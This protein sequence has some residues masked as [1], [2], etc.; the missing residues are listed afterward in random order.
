MDKWKAVKF[1]VISTLAF[2]L[3]NTFAKQLQGFHA[4]EIIFFRSLGSFI[5]CMFILIKNRIPIL[6]TQ[7]PWLIAR[8]IAGAIAMAT[9]FMALQKL[10]FGSVVALRYLSPVFAAL[11]AVFLLKE[12]MYLRQYFFFAMALSGVFLIKGFDLRVEGIGFLYILISAFFSGIV[13]VIIRRIGSSEHPIVIVNYF[14]FTTTVI[15]GLITIFNW[16]SPQGIE[17]ILFLS[18]GLF[19][20]LGQLYMT[21]AFQIEKANI[22]APIKYLEVINALIIGF[23]WFGEG[24]NTL[25]LLGIIILIAGVLLNLLFKPRLNT[26]PGK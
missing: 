17:W 21:K 26:L 18:L 9:F 19:G 24:Y 14:M 6:G 22:V 8:G 23:F 16:Q 1:M 11:L 13:Y 25:S 20:F 12:K 5:L 7:K 15:G 4:F 10:P 3:M 2:T